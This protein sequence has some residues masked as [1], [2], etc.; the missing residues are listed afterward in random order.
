[1]NVEL[2]SPAGSYES[3]Y[4]A[5]NGGAD[6]IYFGAGELN[7]RSRSSFNFKED[8]TNKVVKICEKG[9]V[10]TYLAL[11]A[12]IYDE[13]L[14]K[15]KKVLVSAKEAGVSAIIASDA[16]VIKMAHSLGLRV[17]VSVQA[18]VS[19]TE[20]VRFYSQYADVIVLARELSLEQI[21]E[22]ICN[23]KKEKIKGPSGEL[24][25]IEIFVHGALCV[26]V[27]GKCYMSLAVYNASANRGAC[28]QN[29]RRSYRVIDESNGNELVIDNKFVMSPKDICLIR[30]LDKIVDSGVSILKIEGRGRSPDYVYAVTKAY[31]EALDSIPK[32]QYTRESIEKWEKELG[33]VFNRGFWHGGY[34]L[35]NPMEMW[36]NMPDN[37]A[38]K[39]KVRVGLVTN[40]FAKIKVAE[41]TLR[42]GDMSVGDEILFIGETTGAVKE[43]VKNIRFEEKDISKAGKGMIISI[44]LKNKVRRN[45][46]VFVMK[47]NS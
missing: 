15:G 20:A 43:T 26:S 44:P 25:K 10:K 21:K 3:L 41:I 16:A 38:E 40:Y 4:A 31:R 18:N 22:I 8:D 27:S 33:A 19:N 37:K 14:E 30:C 17:H 34:Y 11:N 45:D 5:I 13:E 32:G 46:A 42:E 7:M 28:Y 24:V 36:S 1:M 9:G 35:G 39:K 23:I 12:V 2:L 6:S 47:L 29:C